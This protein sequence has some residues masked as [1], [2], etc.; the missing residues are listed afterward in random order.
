MEKGNTA[1]GRSNAEATASQ[2][3]FRGEQSWNSIT[4]ERDFMEDFFGGS[5]LLS[6]KFLRISWIIKIRCAAT[7]AEQK[8][9]CQEYN[10]V[11]VCK[12][13]FCSFANSM[14]SLCHSD[15]SSDFI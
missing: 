10:N 5:F 3:C 15:K 7:R 2:A 14:P 4:M 1:F 6:R 12:A 8:L 9:R 13:H 11:G